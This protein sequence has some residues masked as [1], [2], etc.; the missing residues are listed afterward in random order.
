VASSGAEISSAHAAVVWPALDKALAL[1]TFDGKEKV[2][3]AFVKIAKAGRSFWEGDEGIKVKMTKIA[4][5]EAKRNNDAYRPH[6][7][8]SLGVYAEA[9]TDLDMFDEVYGVVAPVVEELVSADR[10]DTDEN[11]KKQGSFSSSKDETATVTAGVAALFRAVNVT[12]GDPSPVSHLP[13]ILE[14]VKP[15]LTSPK[16]TV[17]TRTTLY[18]R[19]KALFDGLRKQKYTQDS[20]GYDLAR[21]IITVL[22]IPSGSGSE[23]VRVKRGEAAEAVVLAATEGVFGGEGDGRNTWKAAIREVADEG[24]QNERSPAVQAVQ[25]RILKALG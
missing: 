9:R 12:I 3:E 18:E 16:S 22:E 21:E 6:A 7:F 17:S 15:V 11:D 1:K 2:L 23:T 24:R 25:D 13:K 5:R 4:V 19:T 14:V 20:D 10:M 8:A